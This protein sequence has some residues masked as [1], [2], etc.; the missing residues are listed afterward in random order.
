MK[1]HK[2]N[3][4]I[5]LAIVW[6]A[7][8]LCLTE[9]C[10][11]ANWI[12]TAYAPYS[13]RYD[14]AFSTAQVQAARRFQAS[15]DGAQ[16]SMT[17]WGETKEN[18]KTDLHSIEAPVIFYSGEAET[19]FPAVYIQ[20]SAPGAADEN[21][22]A[23]SEA[24]ARDLF[25]STDIVGQ[26]LQ[27]GDRKMQ[28]RGVF[29]GQTALALAAAQSSDAL[30]NAELAGV[31][32][33][34]SRETATAYVTTAGL[35]TP[36]QICTGKTWGSFFAALCFVP[37]LVASLRILWAGL[38]GSLRFSPWL[39]GAVWFAAALAL[40][41]LLPYGLAQLPTWLLP[42]QWSNFSFWLEL[43]STLNESLNENLALAPTMRDILAKRQAIKFALWYLACLWALRFGMRLSVQEDQGRASHI[44]KR[45]W[46][47]VQKMSVCDCK[48]RPIVI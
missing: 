45:R 42:P 6:A 39:R 33:G 44:A 27:I 30:E 13:F 48:I 26:T 43:A 23:V 32:D 34:D 21:G 4:I 47:R 10:R 3:K 24:A 18:L 38:R 29:R 36:D 11:A 15:E 37:V 46:S 7:A 2:A 1:L 28:I 41:L 22:C 20:G 14:E 16:Y 17:L 25:G 12:Q 19:A 40:A 8:L 31:P 5:A 9:A 35:G